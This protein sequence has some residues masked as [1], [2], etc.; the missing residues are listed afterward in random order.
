MN[1]TLSV[2]N[3]LL[4]T[5]LPLSLFF[6]QSLPAYA[7]CHVTDT[8][9]IKLTLPDITLS[10]ST[11]PGAILAQKTVDADEAN[12][13]PFLCAGS[14]Q[15]VAL[16]RSSGKNAQGVHATNIKGIG[17]RLFIND[18][19]FPWKMRLDCQQ[20]RCQLPWPVTPRITFQLV[21][22]L[23]DVEVNNVLHSGL[24]G[25]IRA[26]T[27]K[28]AVLITLA[29]SIHLRQESCTV[30]NE[31]VDFGKVLVDPS[32]RPGSNII[33]KAFSIDY[34][35]PFQ[36]SILT[37]WEGMSS[38]KGFLTSPQ[39][40]ERGVAIAIRDTKGNPVYLNRLFRIAP[41]A[42][43]LPFIA[44]LIST[45][46]ISSGPFNATATFHIIYP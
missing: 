5:L 9:T 25:A 24:Y 3:L 43:R 40:L 34:Q 38:A 31:T 46:K 15:L 27:G 21:Q 44:Q 23:P 35:C 12:A 41:Q 32:I 13:D 7:T 29:H 36:S 6:L 4:R 10:A 16:T 45:Q 17:Y 19:P 11:R 14:G 8:Q 30:Q 20:G 37:R 1:Y 26:D 39:L 28:P 22:T 2:S 42:D 33:T 18:H